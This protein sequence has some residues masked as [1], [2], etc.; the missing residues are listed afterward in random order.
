MSLR[1]S[2]TTLFACCAGL[3]LSTQGDA[4][5]HIRPKTASMATRAQAAST[6]ETGEATLSPY[7]FVKGGDSAVDQLPLKATSAKVA[8]S[9][10]IADVKVTQVYRNTG[11]QPLEAIYVFP[12]STRSAVYGMTMTIGERVLKAQIKERGQARTDYEQA[13]AQGRSASLLEQH[14]PN[15]FQMNVANILPG[16]EIK[17]ELSYTELLVPTEGTYAFVYPTVVGPRYAGL[18]GRAGTESSTGEAW[19]ANPYTHA[20]EKPATTFDLEVK[21]AAGMPIQ[22]MSCDTHKTSIA[23]DGKADATLRL[24]PSEAQG[25][26]RDVIVKYQLAGG[27]VQSGLLLDQGREENTFLL[28]AQPPKR[29]APKDLPPREY[30]FIMDVSGSQMGFPIEVSKVLMKEMIQGLRPQDLFN[31]M[32]FEGSSALWSPA[33]QHATPENAQQA[34]AFVRSQNGGGGT[35]LGSAMRRALGLPR[36]PGISRTFVVSTDGY[37]SADGQIFDIIRKNLGSANLFAFGIGSSVNRHLIEGM[38][39]AGQGEA[40]VIT[41]PEQAAAEAEKFRAYVSSPVLTNLK[42]TTHGFHIQDLEPMQL[43]D[44]LADRPVICLGKWTGEARGT[45]TLSGISGVGPWSQTFEVGQVRD[46]QHGALRQ[47]WARQRIQMLSDYD[48]FGQDEGRKAEVTRLGL[49]YH[50]LTA[51]TSFVAVDTQVR[52]ASGHTSTVTQ[53]LP[54]PEGV[55]DAAVGNVSRGMV[56]G[57]AASVACAPASMMMKKAESAPAVMEVVAEDARARR[58]KGKAFRGLR[59]L[60]CSGLTGTTNPQALRQEIQARL[61]DPALASALA[62][63]P[64]GTR[65]VLKVDPSG[66]VLGVTFDH[67]FAGSIQ[68][69]SLLATW[70]LRSWTGGLAGNLELTLG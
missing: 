30:V 57:L 35:E 3:A 37:I 40:F 50:L 4:Q 21:L 43:P 67:A 46:R 5:A 28:M 6:G 59:V 31:V 36:V 70:K 42:L 68:A 62:A 65:V 13:K 61:M 19:V 20:G 55:S 53:P 45:V 11:S 2:T 27:A 49:A 29:V 17:V 34:L 1:R 52:N 12:G 44:V 51:H 25:G 47:L 58:D 16:D 32:V 23:F 15:V 14:R 33:S 7:F 8:I 39:H 69:K 18:T 60:S 48:Q 24:D 64:A 54:L 10:V 56:G 38:A 63:L 66:Q 26:N 41:R 22:R 9:G